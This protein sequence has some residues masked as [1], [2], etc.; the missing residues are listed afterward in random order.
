MA[1]IPLS[2]RLID[3]FIAGEPHEEYC[4]FNSREGRLACLKLGVK[5][6][7]FLPFSTS[8]FVISNFILL[9]KK[10]MVLVGRILIFPLKR[11]VAP[12]KKDA[13][14]ALDYTL[15][16]PLI[17]LAAVLEVVKLLAGSVINPAF[18]FH[19]PVQFP[20]ETQTR[21]YQMKATLLL[22]ALLKKEGL[23]KPEKQKLW[24]LR[25]GIAE[26]KGRDKNF[27]ISCCR[28]VQSLSEKLNERRLL[29]LSE[30]VLTP[31]RP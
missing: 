21:F 20:Q 31:D 28:G 7:V 14:M 30:W 15:M 29:Q 13:W 17:P 8:L 2:C 9:V 25:K 11:E 27:F 10:V 26:K 3:H 4:S 24:L 6:I 12:I 16:F 19:R 18:H 5:K 23:K 22:D 1:H